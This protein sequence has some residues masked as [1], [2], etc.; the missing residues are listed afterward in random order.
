MQTGEFGKIS[1]KVKN[2]ETSICKTSARHLQDAVGHDSWL[3]VPD[4][5]GTSNTHNVRGDGCATQ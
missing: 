1:Y 3:H 4:T 2:L 5:L